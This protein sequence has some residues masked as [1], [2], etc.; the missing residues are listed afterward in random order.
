MLHPALQDA[1]VAE[2]RRQICCRCRDIDVVS[3]LQNKGPVRRNHRPLAQHGDHQH[4]AL[5]DFMQ[6][7]QRDIP[8]LAACADLQLDNLQMSS[9]KGVILQK[10]R[11]LDQAFNLMGS[12]LLRIDNEGER[13]ILAH[14][15]RLIDILRVSDPGNGVKRRIQRMCGHA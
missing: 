4:A 13:K 8:Q 10:A 2:K 5:D 15:I 11:I 9:R 3:L 7:G 12:L 14:G 1:E 6:R